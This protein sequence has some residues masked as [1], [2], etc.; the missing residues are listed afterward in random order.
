MKKIVLKVGLIFLAL[1]FLWF[2][3]LK[4]YRDNKLQRKGNEI[5]NKIEQFKTT[6]KRLPNSLKEIG[7]I[8]EEGVDAL[9][10]S[11]QEKDSENYMISYGTSLGES[12]IYYSDTKK[13]EDFYRE[14]KNRK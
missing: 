2:F 10:Y 13:W 4:D 6:N 12:K 7:L 8:E 1:F 9:Y 3:Y 5:I 11:K 14:M